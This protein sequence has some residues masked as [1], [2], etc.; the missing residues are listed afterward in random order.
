[1][2]END[3]VAGDWL[4]AFVIKFAKAIVEVDARRPVWK[5]YNPGLGAHPET[6]TVRLIASE[7]AR[8][9]PHFGSITLNVSYPANPRKKCDLVIAS[10]PWAIE[11][12]MFR[13][14]GDIGKPNDNMIM[15]I[16]SPYP[17]DRSALTDCDKLISS[18]FSGSLGVLIYGFDYPNLPMDPAMEA[19]EVLAGTRVRLGQRAEARFT[20]LVHP[21]HQ[22]GRVFGWEIQPRGGNSDVKDPGCVLP[23]QSLAVSTRPASAL[24]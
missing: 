21:V 10:P 20:G 23:A 13:L 19:F 12:K 1:V 4:Q 9:E 14:L 24:I 17:I 8:M 15:H 5:S 18:G 16:L 6:E 11:V 7:L 3:R 2:G 22:R